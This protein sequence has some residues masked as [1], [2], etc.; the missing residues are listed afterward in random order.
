MPF[1]ARKT[2]FTIFLL[3]HEL[4]NLIKS[5]FNMKLESKSTRMYR[6]QNRGGEPIYYFLKACIVLNGLNKRFLHQESLK[7]KQTRP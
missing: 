2:K 6:Y 5:A 1:E 3:N 7:F 4:Y